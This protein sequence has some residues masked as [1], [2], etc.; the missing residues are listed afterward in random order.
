MFT[1]KGEKEEGEIVLFKGEE[2]GVKFLY[3]RVR[4]RRI[5]YCV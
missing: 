1:F 4:R 3:L 5:V 2:E